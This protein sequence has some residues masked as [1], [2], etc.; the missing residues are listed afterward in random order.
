MPR[1]RWFLCVCFLAGSAFAQDYPKAELFGGYE[2]R[3]VEVDGT[4]RE[5]VNGGAFSVS[6]NFTRRFALE[7]EAGIYREPLGNGGGTA[8][9]YSYL[10]GPRFNFKHSKRGL[11]FLHSLLGFDHLHGSDFGLPVSDTA[12]AAVLGGGVEWK[13]SDRIGVRPSL[14]YA[15]SHYSATQ[16]DI[17]ASIGF[18]YSFGGQKSTS[19]AVR[20]DAERQFQ[21]KVECSKFLTHLPGAIVG[22]ESP[23]QETD[24]RVEKPVV[25][26]S[27]T[28]NTCLYIRRIVLSKERRVNARVIDLLTERTIED[29]WFNLDEKPQTYTSEGF[30]QAVA[31]RYAGS[32]Q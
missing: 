22:P 17:R 4:T 7:T 32:V 20:P 19:A 2:F 31:E 6:V 28:L 16:N 18:T 13:L 9:V 27:S 11:L 15:L 14:D 26:Y 24:M 25:F 29:Y 8:N 12:I 3:S 5:N 1:L 10:A 30:E 23:D 21:K